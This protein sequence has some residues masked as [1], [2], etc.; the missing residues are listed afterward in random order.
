MSSKGRFNYITVQM[1][2]QVADLT[3]QAGDTSAF[4]KEKY[5]E[6]SFL[7]LA[8]FTISGKRHW[9]MAFLL[10]SFGI[11][12]MSLNMSGFEFLFP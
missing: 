9:D 6:N 2:L 3:A 8:S 1:F 12:Y 7:T 5:G 11:L 4:G 10:I